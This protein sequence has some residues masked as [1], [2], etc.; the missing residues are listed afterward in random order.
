MFLIDDAAD[1]CFCRPVASDD[2]DA[3]V[4]SEYA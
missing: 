3:A 4:W 2:I 1:C